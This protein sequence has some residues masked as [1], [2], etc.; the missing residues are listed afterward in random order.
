MIHYKSEEE[1]GLIRQS[2]L[3]VSSTLADIARILR[4]GLS[5]LDIDRHAEQFILDHGGLPS[6]KNYHGFPNCCCI[7]VNEAIV[8]G[9]P[10]TYQLRE[11]DIV[12]VDC[13]AL[14]QG[15]HG[16]SAYTFALEGA[17]PRALDL[18]AA[19]RCA[20]FLGIGQAVAGNRVGDISHAI[21]E[22]AEAQK[23]YGVVRELVGHGLGRSLHEDPQ[24]PNYGKRGRGQLLKPGLVIA[25]EPMIN[26]GAREVEYL[27]D[28]WTVVTRDHKVS[29]HFEH[30]LVV[31]RGKA[32]ILSDF[33]PI[34]S[35]EKANPELNSAWYQEGDAGLIALREFA[36]N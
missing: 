34:E 2:S 21:Q 5:T 11:G 16:D 25:I 3:L 20:L 30:T 1:I 15:Y 22:Y 14:M 10:G 31:R 33:A 8:H 35:A 12:S 23:Q 6:F 24:I 7:S 17:D 18:M 26:L 28:G 9:I 32:G 27:P 13:G 4:P 19:T 36:R 29:A